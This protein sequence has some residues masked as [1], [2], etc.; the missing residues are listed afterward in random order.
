MHLALKSD[1]LGSFM[2]QDAVEIRHH[3]QGCG[4]ILDVTQ[5]LV[6]CAVRTG[7]DGLMREVLAN[8]RNTEKTVTKLIT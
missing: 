7:V 8:D 4:Q 5:I 3:C 1:T 6:D 2:G